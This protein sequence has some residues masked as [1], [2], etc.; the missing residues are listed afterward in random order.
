[1]RK[2]DLPPVDN[3]KLQEMIKKS[4]KDPTLRKSLEQQIKKSLELKKNSRR[5]NAANGR[6]DFRDETQRAETGKS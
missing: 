2:F 1:M 4:L 6:R 3:A 5:K